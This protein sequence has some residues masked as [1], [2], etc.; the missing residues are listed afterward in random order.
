LPEGT[1]CNLAR[2]PGIVY[3]PSNWK[4]D[5]CT[6]D[7]VDVNAAGI[8]TRGWLPGAEVVILHR[9]YLT[10]YVKA[11][12]EPDP[13]PPLE[14]IGTFWGWR[15]SD[16]NRDDPSQIGC[17]YAVAI[18]ETGEAKGLETRTTTAE[19]CNETSTA[20]Y[21]PSEE[22]ILFG[23]AYRGQ[24]CPTSPEDALRLIQWSVRA[25]N[26]TDTSPDARL[27]RPVYWVGT[28]AFF[29]IIIIGQLVLCGI[30]L[31]CRGAG[32]AAGMFVPDSAG[33]PTPNSSFTPLV[34]DSMMEMTETVLPPR[35][36]IPG[37]G[38]PTPI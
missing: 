34:Q 29:V 1:Y 35:G 38:Q 8:I 16:L 17:C 28:W 10:G 36:S 7:T 12:A 25:E 2:L 5:H 30:V 3:E 21:F 26:D 15:N 4:P 33:N 27:K 37:G 22:K 13:L 19:A 9:E 31:C 18:E 23:F 14:Q 32:R 20:G 6:C 24:N 11:P